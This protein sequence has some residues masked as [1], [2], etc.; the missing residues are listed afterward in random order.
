MK[1]KLN[2]AYGDYKVTRKLFSEVRS[3]LLE[4]LDQVSKTHTVCVVQRNEKEEVAL[5]AKSELDSLLE[6]L[7][8]LK[9][10]ENAKRL[11]SGLD[12]ALRN[13]IIT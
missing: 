13:R 5:I 11:L 3:N 7:Y 10:P 12:R 4:I 9:S 8:L 2:S 1:Q 6:T